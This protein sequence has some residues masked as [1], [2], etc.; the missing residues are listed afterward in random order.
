[1]TGQQPAVNH[2]QTIAFLSHHYYGAAEWLNT[3]ALSHHYHVAAEWLNTEDESARRRN[4]VRV[5]PGR[6]ELLGAV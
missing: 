6:G 2:D 3:E 1:V 4:G 5:D